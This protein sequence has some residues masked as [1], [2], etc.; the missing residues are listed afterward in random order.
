MHSYFDPLDNVAI[1]RDNTVLMD[2][3]GS[4][5]QRNYCTYA[6]ARFLNIAYV[7]SPL[8]QISYEG[9]SALEKNQSDPQLLS[10]YNETFTIKSDLELTQN[11]K[12]HRLQNIN[13]ENF[14]L[15]QEEAKKSRSFHLIKVG[16]PYLISDRYPEMLDCV[17]NISPFEALPSSLFR[18]AIHVR[19]GELFA[20]D[21]HRMLPNCYYVS[22]AQNVI[23]VL[24]KL[25][26]PFICELYTE[27]PS[28]SCVVTPSHHGIDHRIQHPVTL[29]K[30][31]S[32]LED[33]E[34]IPHLKKQINQDPIETLCAI[35]TADLLI[36]SRSSF[37]YLAGILNKRGLVIYHPFWHN[38][39]PIWLNVHQQKYLEEKVQEYCIDWKSAPSVISLL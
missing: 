35:A 8:I 12:V 5:L 19:R 4:Q 9:L 13:L 36:I 34:V 20:V 39:P 22:V 24:H 18:I 28:D 7:H 37:S 26:I 27:L 10:R 32:H 25:G 3:A 11:T 16:F 6:L 33:F 31:M 29:N 1:T 17:K 21:A 23:A 30:E 14:S 2:G 38:A 15:I